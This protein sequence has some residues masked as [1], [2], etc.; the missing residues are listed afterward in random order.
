M[1]LQP[2]KSIINDLQQKRLHV[3]ADVKKLNIQ[4]DIGIKLS[5]RKPLPTASKL[6][7]NVN[8]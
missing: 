4:V 2:A 1:L 7:I 6:E 3:P 8:G 5:D